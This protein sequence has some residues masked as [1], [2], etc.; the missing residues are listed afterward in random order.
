MLVR[1]TRFEGTHWPLWRRDT[2][3]LG[4]VPVP[5]SDGVVPYYLHSFELNAPFIRWLVGKA[6][7]EKPSPNRLKSLI[8]VGL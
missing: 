7:H 8:Y 3:G 2:G 5:V 6:G 1:P 4:A